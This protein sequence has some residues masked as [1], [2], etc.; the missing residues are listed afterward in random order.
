[1]PE[2]T[3]LELIKLIKR[4]SPDTKTV[5]IT[6]YTDLPEFAAKDLGADE[7]LTKPVKLNNVTEMLDKYAGKTIA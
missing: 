4:N 3:G 1:M 6:G 7:Y 2:M 5:M